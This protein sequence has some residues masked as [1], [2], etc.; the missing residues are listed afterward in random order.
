MA[1]LTSVI[2]FFILLFVTYSY[3]LPFVPK[4]VSTTPQYEFT[5]GTTTVEHGLVPSMQLLSDEEST[6][7][8]N[9]HKPRSSNDSS[10]EEFTTSNY[11]TFSPREFPED[12]FTSTTPESESSEKRNF[13]ELSSTTP[14][15]ES[16]EKRSFGEFSSTTPESSTEFDQRAIRPFESQEEFETS[17]SLYSG[18]HMGSNKNFQ[19]SSS[20]D[21]F[22]KFT[23]LL[24]KGESTTY[25]YEH[26]DQSSEES[27]AQHFGQK[28][29]PQNIISIIPGKI[30]E[31]K[32][33]SNVQLPSSSW[34][35]DV[36]K[37]AVA[38]L[39]KN[40]SRGLPGP[41]QQLP[42]LEY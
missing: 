3:S 41:K 8:P 42:Q 39:Q 7:V 15:S 12:E 23:G 6:G 20:V 17:T 5:T 2:S 18:N 33:Y 30:T 13:E 38:K 29:Q 1:S 4:S 28:Q 25:G 24:Q 34:A 31:T 11:V 19:P 22:G 37:R 26:H 14:E 32:I 10:S 27:S 9:L 21:S 40:P 16:N 36:E 35:T